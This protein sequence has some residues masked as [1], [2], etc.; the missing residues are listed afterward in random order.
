MAPTV[1]KKSK[2]ANAPKLSG[3]GMK[4]A[5]LAALDNELDL[6]CDSES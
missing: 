6:I 1:N 3:K 4:S 5:V 2:V